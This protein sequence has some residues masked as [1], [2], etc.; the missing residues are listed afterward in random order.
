MI[1]II[2]SFTE[3]ETN[4]YAN[5]VNTEECISTV[6]KFKGDIDYKD[7][8]SKRNQ[9]CYNRVSIS[10][11]N[12]GMYGEN[13]VFMYIENEIDVYCFTYNEID[14]LLE[15]KTNPH[16]KNK[17]DKDFIKTLTYLKQDIRYKIPIYPLDMAID[18]FHRPGTCFRLTTY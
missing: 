8:S 7:V 2:K 14:F 10:D 4:Q 12:I 11:Q 5:Q 18:M 3:S 6:K 9:Q 15:T 13:Q 16:S 1:P 17:L